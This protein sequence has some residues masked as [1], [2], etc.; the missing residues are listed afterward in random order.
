MISFLIDWSIWSVDVPLRF[1][2]KRS[3]MTITIRIRSDLVHSHRNWQYWRMM[4]MKMKMYYEKIQEILQNHYEKS[5]LNVDHYLNVSSL[6]SAVFSRSNVSSRR[7]RNWCWS[8]SL[9][10]F[11]VDYSNWFDCSSFSRVSQCSEVLN[12]R[13]FH[14]AKR[15]FLFICIEIHRFSVKT[16]V[17]VRVL[18]QIVPYEKFPR[19]E[20]HQLIH[21][22][23]KW[24][25]FRSFINTITIS[26]DAPCEWRKEIDRK[27]NLFSNKIMLGGQKITRTLTRHV[28]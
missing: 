9:N 26:R 1:E 20:Y 23:K 11:V 28:S 10:F 7:M 25:E 27:K 16:L 8:D 3:T 2:Y 22:C 18:I 4:K 13:I 14:F 15:F 17:R 6:F 5:F 12:R 24:R 21:L 19:S